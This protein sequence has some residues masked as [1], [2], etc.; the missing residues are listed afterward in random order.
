MNRF[1]PCLLSLALSPALFAAPFPRTDP[2]IERLYQYPLINGRSPS[3]PE[4]APDGSKIA[5]GWNTTG[6]RKLDLWV[7]DFPGGQKRM[8]VDASKIQDLPRQDD[9]RT[10][11]EKSEQT[12]YDGGIGGARWSPDSR[13]LLFSYKERTWL[14][15]PDG[16]DLHPLVDGRASISN[17]EFSPDGRYISYSNGQNLFRYDLATGAVKQLT[18]LSKANTSIGRAIWSPDSKQIAVTWTDSSKEGNHVLMD[19][20]KD[21]AT[22]VNIKR[23]W[24]GDLSVNNQV[25]LVGVDGGIVRFVGDLPS[26]LWVQD[27]VWAPDSS[28]FA[29][30]WIQGDDK[31]FT[32]SVVPAVTLK[33][34]DVYTETPPDNYIVDWRPIAWTQIG[35]ASC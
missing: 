29:I 12:L 20:S 23:E 7:M 10:D 21:R 34:A 24:N 18:F 6:I 30:S 14:V 13:L 2:T 8:I 35:R 11:L 3:S 32:L 9:S 19:F 33:K 26:Y 17:P 25:G 22:V 31:K 5:F 1:L 15:R 28:K 27:V 16:K 4:M